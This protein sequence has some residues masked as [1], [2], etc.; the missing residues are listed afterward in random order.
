MKKFSI[1]ISLMLAV[2]VQAT[3]TSCSS[4]PSVPASFQEESRQP[5]I[6]PDYKDII[7]PNNIAPMNFAVNEGAEAVVARFSSAAGEFTYGEDNKV[8]IDES[9]WKKMLE[10]SKGKDICVE[11]FAQISGQWK[12]FKSFNIHVAEEPIDEYVSYRLI[13]PSYVAY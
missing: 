11:V 12:K 13:Q 6:Y 3:F 10:S 5:V 2:L 7:I 8:V 9:E 4:T 1:I